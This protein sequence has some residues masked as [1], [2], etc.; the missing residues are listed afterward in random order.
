[1]DVSAP[2]GDRNDYPGTPQY[3]SFGNLILS[4]YPE[5]LARARNQLDP[6]GT[7]TVPNVLRDCQNGVCAYYQYL[8]GTSMASPHA[9][10]VAALIVSEYGRRDWGGGLTMRPS[11]VERR[12]LRTADET[13]CPEPRTVEYIVGVGAVVDPNY[14]ATCEGSARHNSFYGDGI[15]DAA[16]AVGAR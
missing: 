9:A 14:T 1:V 4:T 13:P 12:L 11:L 16:A 5:S 8:Q 7:P 3:R 15:V 6:S 10:G 2:G